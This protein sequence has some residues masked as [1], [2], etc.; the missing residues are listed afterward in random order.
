M[1]MRLTLLTPLFLCSGIAVACLNNADF[2]TSAP[3]ARFISSEILVGGK[4]MLRSS[5]SDDGH[6]NAD[7]VWAYL[8]NLEFKPTED[9]TQSQKKYLTGDGIHFADK[10]NERS[11]ELKIAYGGRAWVRDLKLEQKADA[12]VLSPGEAERYAN[13]RWIQ[14]RAV[15]ALCE[16]NNGK[17]AKPRQGKD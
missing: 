2:T 6:A 17:P 11:I 5:T 1:R 12:W 7:L 9:F 4:V 8:P 16:V 13:Y 10:K 14:R 3:E 15:E